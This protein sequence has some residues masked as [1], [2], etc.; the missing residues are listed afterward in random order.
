MIP[1]K[2]LRLEGPHRCVVRP[3]DVA[4]AGGVTTLLRMHYLNADLGSIATHY[5]YQIGYA[6]ILARI[7]T[8][9]AVPA[10]YSATRYK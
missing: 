4:N 5:M 7:L 6:C 9:N 2:S 3:K 10:V 8:S 1:F